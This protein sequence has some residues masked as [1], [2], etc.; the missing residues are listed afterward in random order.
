MIVELGFTAEEDN[1]VHTCTRM[2]R[3]LVV[4]VL[5]AL[6]APAR[7]DVA[8]GRGA[9]PAGSIA[10]AEEKLRLASHERQAAHR[11]QLI[12]DA[13]AIARRLA[14]A[15]P[16]DPEPHVLLARAISL[17]DPQHPE[18]C[19]PGVCEQAIAELEKARSL[20]SDG[21]QAE[22][23]ASELGIVLSRIGRFDDALVEYDRA[24]KRVDPERLLSRWDEHGGQAIL[25]GN[26]AE[27]LMALGRLDQAIARY[28]QARD[29]SEA[30]GLEWQLSNWGLGVALDRDEQA[31]AGRQAIKKA[32]ERDPALA[33]LSSD[34]VFFEP[35]GD[36]FYYLALGH[37]VA[38]D[39]SDAINAWK[40]YLGSS[41]SPRFAR[42]ARA[43]LDALKKLKPVAEP[44]APIAFGEPE[45]F[46]GLRS[47]SELRQS[48]DEHGEDVRICYQR[49][50]R[51]QPGLRG[52]LFLTFDVLPSGFPY[53]PPRVFQTRVD[54]LG[55]GDPV[56][57]ELRR[58]VELAASYWRF[59]NIERPSGSPS[60]SE[61]VMVRVQLGAVK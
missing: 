46:I 39:R 28:R 31:E 45:S 11:E 18:M 44:A 48:L 52:E 5:Y 34:G 8:A 21:L 58:C 60:P 56:V 13:A 41:L 30:G 26:S 29:A 14:T 4:L 9:P 51:V 27:T 6:A 37:E 20:D 38:G 49:A 16:R 1:M 2:R 7:A 10:E 25:Y 24:L 22:K 54:N 23:I 35:A 32:L 61:N 19:K 47:V 59:P 17:A 42:R 40:A 12:D 43:H 15:R 55:D 53:P 3:R 36:K 50:L 57:S 33:Q